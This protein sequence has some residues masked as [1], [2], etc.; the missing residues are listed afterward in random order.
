MSRVIASRRLL[1]VLMLVALAAGVAIQSQSWIPATAMVP[2]VAMVLVSYFEVLLPLPRWAVRNVST[3]GVLLRDD[4]AEVTVTMGFCVMPFNLTVRERLPEGLSVIP[5]SPSRIRIREGRLHGTY[6]LAA[7]RRGDWDLGPMRIVRQ[8]MI[9]LFER[10]VD[11]PMST[12]VTVLPVTAK[13]HGLRLRPRTLLPEG[14]PTRSR[15]HGAG[16]TFY[17]LREFAAGDTLSDVNWKATARYDRPFVNEFLPDEPARYMVY[18]DARAFGAEVGTED[19][20]ERTLEL[21]AAL[22]EGLITANA[23]VGIVLLSYNASFKVP[24]S[25]AVHNQKIRRMILQAKPGPEA[26]LLTLVEAGAPHLP[27]RTAAILITP[28][29]YEPTLQQALTFLR[30]HHGRVQLLVP[31]FPEPDGDRQAAQRTAGSLLNADQGAV[32]ADL[33][34]YTDGAVQWP[35]GEPIPVT[36]GRL[37]LTG[38]MR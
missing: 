21:S 35:H 5:G 31:S 4:E 9:G 12:Q 22:M 16:D 2:L 20:F 26:P 30:A 37:G 36:L 19:V 17:A 23:H 10:A 13:Q 34:P 33:A 11:V 15:R 8:S 38:R 18:I 3:D 6:M 32:L 7:R 1:A 25:G 14:I 29:L 24:A 28:N 27:R